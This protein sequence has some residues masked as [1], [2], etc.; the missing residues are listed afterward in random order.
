MCQCILVRDLC[1]N[2]DRRN[3]AD[4]AREALAVGAISIEADVWLLGETLH[5]RTYFLLMYA[6]PG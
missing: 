6:Q 3:S 5:V 4:R 2:Y 1:R